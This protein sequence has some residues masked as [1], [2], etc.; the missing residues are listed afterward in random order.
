MPWAV[1]PSLL[2]DAILHWGHT[3]ISISHSHFHTEDTVNGCSDTWL[4]SEISHRA[5]FPEEQCSVTRTVARVLSAPS[6]LRSLH[7]TLFLSQGLIPGVSLGR[8]AARHQTPFKQQQSQ[9]WTLIPAKC[10]NMVG[11][12]KESRMPGGIKED[13]HKW[14]ATSCSQTGR[15]SLGSVDSPQNYL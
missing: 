5:D 1:Y 15:F 4:S 13:I 10:Q 12:K 6:L 9:E 11:I 8:V 7:M 3:L 14:R 2:T